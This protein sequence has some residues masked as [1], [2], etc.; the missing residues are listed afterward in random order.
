MK[1][2]LLNLH[3]DD[4]G[5]AVQF[6]L[7]AAAVVVP[8]IIALIAFGDDIVNW[9]SSQTGTVGDAEPGEYE[10]VLN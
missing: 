2:F 10:Q 9:L 7:V 5:D 8:L 6:I 3:R 1:K 4:R